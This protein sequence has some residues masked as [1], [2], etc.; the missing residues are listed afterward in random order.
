MHSESRIR[1]IYGPCI[2]RTGIASAPANTCERNVKY[3]NWLYWVSNFS[4]RIHGLQSITS[5]IDVKKCTFLPYKLYVLTSV[6]AT[7]RLYT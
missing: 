6:N 4:F 5:I 7:A 3:V 1:M 2:N